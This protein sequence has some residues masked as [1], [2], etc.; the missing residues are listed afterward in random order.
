SVVRN[1]G[2]AAAER[3][4][5]VSRPAISRH[6]AEL[7]A[8]LGFRLC[9]RGRGGFS[10]TERGRLT[11]DAAVA[12]LTSLDGFHADLGRIRQKIVGDL[13]IGMVD[14]V[15]SDPK[16]RIKPALAHLRQTSDQVHITLQVAAPNEIERLLEEGRLD[17][18]ILPR[19]R[20]L[21]SL[22]YEP[23]YSERLLLYCGRDHPLFGE[24][25]RGISRKRIMSC[26]YAGRGYTFQPG[27]EGA[28]TMDLAG[29]KAATAYQIEG[30][31]I[32]IQ[33]GHFI[34]HLPT[35]YAQAWVERG[36]MRALANGDFAYEIQMTAVTRR[37]RHR[38]LALETFL[39]K[40]LDAA[41]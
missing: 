28:V 6:M 30:T 4:L 40:L 8:R 41:P 20:T 32:L 26:A 34:G 29:R 24:P 12:M 35:H 18:G 36:E 17:L 38:S 3:E 23:L 19:H 7:E 39:D 13:K 15:I 31:A 21:A 1:G 16:C 11:H 25:A 27:E 37:K 2:F 22:D 14:N 5:G 10:L 33:S 9:E